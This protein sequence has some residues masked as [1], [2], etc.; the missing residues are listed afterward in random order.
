MNGDEHF[1]KHETDIPGTLKF[2]LT[3]TAQAAVFCFSTW[4]GEELE[5]VK[6]TR[7]IMSTS[8]RDKSTGSNQS[9]LLHAFAKDAADI[10]APIR[11][12][13]EVQS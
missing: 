12:V 4:A 1:I 5:Y 9:D 7:V 6:C 2:E 11:C 3:P 8:Q 13:V 10:L